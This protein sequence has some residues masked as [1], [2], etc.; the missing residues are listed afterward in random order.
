VSWLGHTGHTAVRCQ[1]QSLS[2]SHT[3]RTDLATHRH[4]TDSYPKAR[5]AWV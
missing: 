4:L 3:K 2:D 5:L 1:A